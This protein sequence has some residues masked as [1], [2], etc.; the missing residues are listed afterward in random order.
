MS[1]ENL[2][3]YNKKPDVVVNLTIYSIDKKHFKIKNIDFID[4]EYDRLCK[5]LDNLNE[6]FQGTD[7]EQLEYISLTKKIISIDEARSSI[8]RDLQ[9]YKGVA[10]EI[11]QELWDRYTKEMVHTVQVGLFYDSIKPDYK[12]ELVD[13]YIEN[14]NYE[15]E[16]SILER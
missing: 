1:I 2:M 4:K 7:K 11:H 3:I 16:D 15:T 13:S 5:E 6:N 12:Y 8:A 9:G 14:E 10:G